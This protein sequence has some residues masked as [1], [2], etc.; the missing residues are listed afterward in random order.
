MNKA[1]NISKQINEIIKESNC[2]KEYKRLDEIIKKDKEINDLLE[3]LDK[4][5]KSCLKS[6]EQKSNEVINIVNSLNEIPLYC[7]YE[8]YKKELMDLLNEI[9]ELINDELK[10]AN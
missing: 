10:R 2:Y 5:K 7:E 6:N 9:K 1:F 4:A 3:K 8:N